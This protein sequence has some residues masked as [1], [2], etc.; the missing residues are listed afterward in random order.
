MIFINKLLFRLRLLAAIV[1]LAG[2]APALATDPLVSA[3][4]PGIPDKLLGEDLPSEGRLGNVLAVPIPTSDPT[5][6]TGLIGV[7]AYFWDQTEAQQAVQPPSVT[8]LGGMYT[9]SES[10]AAVL[11]QTLY[12][13]EARW[14]LKTGVATINLNLHSAMQ[15]RGVN[16]EG[17]FV[18]PRTFEVA[19]TGAFQVVDDLLDVEGTE[20]ELGK[21]PGGD[22]ARHQPTFPA[23]LGVEASRQEASALIERA[24]ASLEPFGAA[25][26][27]LR[28]LADFVLARSS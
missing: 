22:A 2:V 6:G 23:L 27:P 14:R 26:D 20:A 17:D 4:Q 28:G 16:R 10:W 3:D 5:I 21:T 1:F 8:A 24:V 7:T 9:D 25:A 12:W 18:N 15:G 13:A 19:A 11:G